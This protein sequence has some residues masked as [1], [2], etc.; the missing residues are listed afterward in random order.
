MSPELDGGHW[1][2]AGRSSE[3]LRPPSTETW[4]IVEQSVLGHVKLV[5]ETT[6]EYSLPTGEVIAIYELWEVEPPGCA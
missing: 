5:D 6:I 4:P 1:H 3:S 2:W